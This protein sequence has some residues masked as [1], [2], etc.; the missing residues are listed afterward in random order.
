MTKLA[1]LLGL[2]GILCPA[3]AVGQSE[4]AAKV[5]RAAEVI[6]EIMALPDRSIPEYLFR[7]VGRQRHVRRRILVVAGSVEG[8]VRFQRVHVQDEGPSGLLLDEAAGFASKERRLAQPLGKPGG[9]PATE[10]GAVPGLETVAEKEVMVV[11]CCLPIAPGRLVSE[12]PLSEVPG[13]VLA[14]LDHLRQTGSGRIEGNV[15]LRA[16]ARVG[17]HTGWITYA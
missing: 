8:H 13:D 12:V 14:V 1:T 3:I 16:A 15:V 6:D 4:A 11:G 5:D 2:L 10:T 9:F 7:E 17:V